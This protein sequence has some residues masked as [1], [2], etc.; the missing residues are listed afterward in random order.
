MGN[1]PPSG[2]DPP[3]AGQGPD[4]GEMKDKLVAARGADRM[5]LI[6]GLVF[7][8]DSFL[9]WYGVGITVLGQHFGANRTGWS[10][11]GL[12]VL[13]VLFAILDTDVRKPDRCGSMEEDRRACHVGQ[14][15]GARQMVGLHVGFDDMGDTH[16]LLGRGLEIRLDLQL[17]IH[18]SAAGCPPSAEQVARAPGLRRQE[19]T[20]DHDEPSFCPCVTLH[21]L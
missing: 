5:I 18:H 16:R 19:L 14:S 1:V 10:V 17:W 20:K 7:F 6:A 21:M 12:A 8:V 2:P 11:G 15:A 9:P 13:A 3:G 4:W